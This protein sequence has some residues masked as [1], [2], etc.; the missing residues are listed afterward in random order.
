MSYI[1]SIVNRMKMTATAAALL[2]ELMG[3]NRNIA[4]HEKVRELKWED[5]EVRNF[6][7]RG[8]PQIFFLL[9][10]IIRAH[11]LYKTSCYRIPTCRDFEINK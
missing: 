1:G 6:Y 3:R 7:N 8:Y 5:R 2:D 11:Q 10:V 4:P 9:K